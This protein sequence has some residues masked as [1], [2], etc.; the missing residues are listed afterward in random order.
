MATMKAALAKMNVD[1]GRATEQARELCRA[2]A[3]MSPAQLAVATEEVDGS[4]YLQVLGETCAALEAMCE[5]YDALRE[6]IERG[7][8]AP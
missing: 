7:I 6:T 8:A 4:S 3:R 5:A 1:L 2:M